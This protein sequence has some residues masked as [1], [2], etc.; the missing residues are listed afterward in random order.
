MSTDWIVAMPVA[1]VLCMALGAAGDGPQP[2]VAKSIPRA[3]TLHGETRTDNYFWLR[4][5]NNPEVIRHLE[6]ENRYTAAVMK[7][8]E[9]LQARLYEEILARIQ[10]TDL[11]VPE[12]IGD[13]FYYARTEEGKQY[14]IFCRKK[15]GLQAREE[16][17]LDQN[18]LAQGH[19]YFRVGARRVSPDHRLLAYSTD[20]TGAEVYTLV[21]KDLATGRLLPDQIPN[22][23]YSLEWGNDNQHVFYVT[24]DE[25]KRPYRAWRHRLGT[26]REDDA[27]LYEEKDEMFFLRVTKT[28]SKR[29][30]LLDLE[31]KTTSEVHYLEAGQPAGQFR[32]FHPRQHLMEYSVDHHGEKFYIVTNDNAK[33]FKVMETPVANTAKANW[34]EFLPHRPAVKVDG[35]E[36]F[37]HHLVV[38]ERENGLR[39]MRSRD[40]RNGEVHYV[41]FPEPVYTF[42]PARTEEFDTNLLRF[43]YTSLVTPRSVFDYNLETRRRELQKEYE[44][45]GGYDRARYQS[46]RLFA[47][48]PDGA[49]VPISLVYKKGLA[50]S[51]KNPL[52][53]YGYGS[54][55]MPNEPGFS[56]DRL[57]LL[58]RGFVYALAHIRG[59]GEMGRP[60]Y[61]DGKLLRKKNTFTDFIACAEHLVAQKYTSPERLAIYG[62]SA[63]GLLMG[64][65]VNLR[66]ELFRVVVAKVPFVDVINTMIDP[67][68]PLTVTEWEE[69][70]NP[71]DKQ[72]YE[73]MKS[74]SPYDN[75]GKK[76]YPHMLVTSGLNDPRVAYW[77]P[78][79]WT[80]KL[81]ATKTDQNVLLL[82]TNLGA[83]HG[84][85][86]GRYERMKETAFDYAFI[87]KMLGMERQRPESKPAG[88]SQ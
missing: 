20:T 4:D 5:R 41:E 17:L 37:R 73:Y 50:K 66:P 81:R 35:L 84:G 14:G 58:D 28:K 9:P 12:K 3:A 83:G 19:K 36:T 63:G 29:Y 26:R 71:K 6:A 70:G 8:T 40:M 13:Y 80:A 76:R 43:E 44:V 60:W 82:K 55:G 7:D 38:Y 54:Y 85:P 67:T 10:Q 56:S 77:E 68:I 49:R 21:F 18:E 86:S 30:L 62:G 24:L 61:E 51:G 79:K 57:S 42:Q 47:T 25:A 11:S 88:S 34:K 15:G 52:L 27:L 31:S 39:A 69:W 32:V 45:L 72:Y 59:G 22:T 74:Y 2:P 53:L 48:A 78:A 65:V 46:E 1:L 23:Y 87:L 64:A 16:V 33:N 75:V